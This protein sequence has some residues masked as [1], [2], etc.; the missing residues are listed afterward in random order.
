MKLPRL[1]L[2][3]RL[4]DR[5]LLREMLRPMALSLA[6]V[7][8]ALLLERVLRLVD[9]IATEGGPM[10]AVV[11]MAATLLPH[12]LG[13]ALPASFFLSML[14]LV[15]RLSEDSEIDALL[16]SGLSLQRIVI[17]FLAVG[18]LLSAFS[19]GLFGYV[20]PHARYG[21]RA[22]LHLV[23]HGGWTGAV[24]GGAFVA[25]GNG[26][27]IHAAD[28]DRSGRV[29][30]GVLIEERRP[31]GRTVTTTANRGVLRQDPD[32]AGRLLLT[33]SDGSQ[34]RVGADGAVTVLRFTE[35]TIGRELALADTLFRP[36]GRD[37]REMTLTELWEGVRTGDGPV[38]RDSM[39]GELHG[40]LVQAA[41]VTALPL[42]AVPM[43][44][45][46]KRRR[47]GAGVVL[48][49]VILVLY[50]HMLQVGQGL[51]ELGR[52]A[53]V[54]GSWLPFAALTAAAAWTLSRTSGRPGSSPIEAALVAIEGSLETA[55]SYVGRL[56]RR[57][58]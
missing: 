30:G 33:L 21:Y 49:A 48:A 50:H 39:R 38:S 28:A 22:A 58:T 27:T 20:Q 17:P 47:R 54:V 7:L 40:R 46:A 43:G 8:A 53:P 2:P 13:L 56:S 18:V 19:L 3:G 34:M 55:V 10:G 6:F 44:V 1:R 11:T 9:L 45:A 5:Y 15:A 4:I 57:A 36:R 31:D 42:L 37:E 51:V 41:S 35:L 14:V 23:K 26:V 25:A 16:S 29:L 12:Y 32:R 24:P 52:V